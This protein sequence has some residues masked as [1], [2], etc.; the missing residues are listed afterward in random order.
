[1]EEIEV[2]EMPGVARKGRAMARTDAIVLG[3]GI[4]EANTLFPAAFPA[5]LK[6]LIR[7]A[8]KW[9]PEANYHASFLARIMPWLLAFRR[10]S[11]P[12][13]LLATM[14]AMRP[15][16]S[17]ALAELVALMAEARARR[18][19]RHT[20]WLKLYRSDRSFT[21]TARERALAAELGLPVNVMDADDARVLEPA[22]APVFRHAIFWEDAASVTN[23][24]A[25]TRAY[26]ARFAAL[27]G[28]TVTGDARSLHRVGTL[29]RVDTVQGPIDAE[30]VVVTL[31]PWAPDLLGPLGIRL[32]L[33]VKRGYHRHYRGAGNAALARPVVDV[34]VGYALAPMA[35]GIRVTTGAEFAPRDAAPTPVQLERL[36]PK[37]KDLFPLGEPVEA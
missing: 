7:I 23:P 32:P 6:A 17:R 11:A 27:G 12:E 31:G 33:A 25:L 29:W 1:M 8:L 14:Q 35:Q 2:H 13:R 24:L 9:A 22:L 18:Y 21:G 37:A 20:G 34:D 10:N 36:L 26:A 3:A 4:I 28:V 5:S 30:A 16:F 15:L 19:L